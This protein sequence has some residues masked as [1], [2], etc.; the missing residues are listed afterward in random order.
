[1]SDSDIA[2]QAIRHLLA[3]YGR[4]LDLRH[5]QSWAGLFLSEG[6]WFGGERYG[7]VHGRAALAEFVTREFVA[8]APSVHFFGN[9]AITV[10]GER[11]DAWSRCL[12][13]ES[14]HGGLHIALAGHYSDDLAR[15]D[16]GWRFRRREVT[17]D[18]PLDA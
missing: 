9:M 12:L 6:E 18:L 4:L 15:T 13:V 16:E 1:M 17:V 2:D 11:A 5:A 14:G 3:E 8:T 7:L 10:K